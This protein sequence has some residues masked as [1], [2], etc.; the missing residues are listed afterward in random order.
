[1][2]Q[3]ISFR[4]DVS[5]EEALETIMA[6]DG[7]NRS[8]AIRRALAEAQAVRRRAAIRQEALALRDDRSDREEAQR[9]LSEMEKLRAW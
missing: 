7:V 3:T 9:V 2:T 8:E 1:M 6:T 5:D 4:P